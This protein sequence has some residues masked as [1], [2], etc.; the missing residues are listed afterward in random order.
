MSDELTYSEVLD[1]LP[2]YALGALEPEEM[3]AVDA[4]IQKHEQLLDRLQES[5]QAAVQLAYLAPTV[6]LPSDAK[7]RLMQRVR[8]DLTTKQTD[9]PVVAS[10][11]NLPPLTQPAALVDTKQKYRQTSSG[12]FAAWQAA[13]SR[14]NGWTWATG[15]ALIALL[16]VGFYA[17]QNIN[18]LQARLHQVEA[19]RDGLQAELSQLEQDNTQIQAQLDQV[20]ADQAE[21]QAEVAQLET[22]N[23]QIGER[24]RQTE[25]RRDQLQAQASQLQ[26]A[27]EALKQTNQNLVQQL[28]TEQSHLQLVVNNAPVLVPGTEE[29]P[30]ALGVMYPGDRQALL[31]LHGLEPLPPGETY[32]LW[33]IPEGRAPIPAGLVSV[34]AEEPTLFLVQVPSQAQDYASVGVSIEPSSGSTAPTGPIVLLGTVS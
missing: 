32:Q 28:Q 13:L 27:N 22:E 29:A 26:A 34:Q 4:Y 12:W 33:L 14:L 3:L 2:A 9:G 15:A 25:A 31:I 24:L 6:P 1:K 16:I 21:V 5:E 18:Q 30:N 19:S 10:A 23:D 20:K 7:E 17:Y 11:P 8:A